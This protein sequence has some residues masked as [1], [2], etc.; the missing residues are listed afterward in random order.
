MDLS[1]TGLSKIKQEADREVGHAGDAQTVFMVNIHN[2]NG[3]NSMN[4]DFV[5][6]LSSRAF[7]G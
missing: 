5:L 6:I 4:G 1:Q 2:Q 3:H 7:A